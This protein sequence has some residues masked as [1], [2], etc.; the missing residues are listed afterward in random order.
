MLR[1]AS[2]YSTPCRG[3]TVANECHGLDQTQANRRVPKCQKA[4]GCGCRCG[5]LGCNSP[6]A[7]ICQCSECRW[8]PAGRAA[9]LCVATGFPPRNRVGRGGKRPPTA[10]FAQGPFNVLP[11]TGASAI[12]VCDPWET[13]AN[14]WSVCPEGQGTYVESIPSTHGRPTAIVVNMHVTALQD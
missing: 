2:Q 1:N 4:G 11:R 7:N 8:T 10:S 14:R 3:R 6:T 9:L 13:L 12:A 5:Q